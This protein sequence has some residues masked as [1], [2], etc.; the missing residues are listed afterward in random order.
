M[1]FQNLMVLMWCPCG[2]QMAKSKEFLSIF[3]KVQFFF[4]YFLKC[5]YFNQK[6]GH[7]HYQEPFTYPKIL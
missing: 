3:L 1:G 7:H 2:T 5:L 4:K 6:S